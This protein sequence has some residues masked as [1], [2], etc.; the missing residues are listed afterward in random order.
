MRCL[1]CIALPEKRRPVNSS[2]IDNTSTHYTQLLFSLR[3]VSKIASILVTLIGFVVIVG[4]MFDIAALKS[5]L[6]IWVTMKANT[7]IGFIL[8]GA[9]L[10]QLHRPT[11][12]SIQRIQCCAAVVLLIGLLT[13]LEYG[14]NRDLGIDQLIFQE[15][16][17]AVA[18]SAPGRMAVNTAF[19]FL[20][21]GSAL[22]LLSK[23]RSL[24]VVIQAFTI[25]VFFIAML[26][27]L[28]YLYNIQEFYGFGA[29]TK[30]AVHTAIAFIILCIGMLCLH[31]NQ[32]IMGT[33]T[34]QHAGGIMARRL[35]LTVL[36]VPPLLSWFILA[37]YRNGLYNSE[38]GLS[39]SA[40]F[41]VLVFAV[42]IWFNARALGK[43]DARRQRAEERSQSEARFRSLITATSQIVWTTNANGRVIEDSPSWRAYTG[44]NFEEYREYG[45]LNTIHPNDRDG[46]EE[47]WAEAVTTKSLYMDEYRIQSVHGSYRYFV[48]RGVPVLAEDGSIREWIG[49]CTDIHDRKLAES[50]LAENEAKFRYL[51]ENATDLIW[52]STLEGILTYISPRFKEM[53]GYEPSDFLGQ[54]FAPLVHS[55]DLP[56]CLA[57]LNR[58]V[59]TGQKQSGFEFRHIRKDGSWFWA[60]SN[61]SPVK[62]S[63]GTVVGLQGIIQDITA[64]KEAELERQRLVMLIE[65]SRDFIGLASL[66]GHLMFINAAALDMVGLNSQEEAKT[67]H[68]TEFFLPDDLDTVQNQ[69]LP[70]VMQCGSWQG[71]FRLK[72]FGT[73]HAISVD[74]NLFLVD[75]PITKMPLGLATVTRDITDRKRAEEALRESEA[76]LRQ[77]ATD[78]GNTLA[79]LQRTQTQLVQSEKMSSLGQ[80][81]A[82]VAHEINNPVN[83]IYGNLSHADEYAQDLLRLLKLYQHHHPNPHPEVQ[84]EANTI[85]LEFLVE[86]LPKLLLSMKVGAERI[87]KI[88][89]S[90]RNFSRMDE[91]DMKAVNIHEG[92]ESTLLILQNR[93]KDRPEHPA[94]EVIKEYGDLP[95]IECY[96][97]QLNQV[98][99]NII[100]NALDALEERDQH[101]TLEDIKQNP[102]QIRICTELT[103][104]NRAII[105]I[106]DNGPGISDTV[107]SYLFNP[108]FTTKPVGKG[109]GLGMSISY[110][111]VTEK[112]RGSLY[113][114]SQ[115][116]QGAEFVIEIPTVL[117]MP[118]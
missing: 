84:A 100:S 66:D 32:G 61:V 87:Q 85:D 18:T 107:K 15:S 50:A 16:V 54:S 105:R 28:G 67:K 89:R 59:A 94:I 108:F 41:S 26:G 86:D 111:I 101:R 6:P 47:R 68:I 74:Y 62:N 65:R 34:S 118:Y 19:N 3:S 25:T 80:L 70:T 55:D 4:W 73:G 82:G 113:C 114:N 27:L 22:L 64:R 98:F 75:D 52:S 93:L 17:T 35:F 72:H 116:G 51:V 8:S 49:T 2:H 38:V 99:M 77:K 58:V 33:L 36:S 12:R 11:R 1:A 60:V 46:A 78:L 9:S 97:G 43:I 76:K 48:V 7:A 23:F 21:V 29:Y 13:L 91:S 14:F 95:L 112:H 63:A 109:T 96:A 71:D 69:I 20:L 40:V 56:A 31:P 24:Q 42:L 45:W 30:M 92:L 88:V 90:L 44:Q 81:V 103:G 104:S 57:F 117:K 83:F 102:S 5:I 10:W 79:E 53:A 37:G 39:F 110:Q 106:I 115:L